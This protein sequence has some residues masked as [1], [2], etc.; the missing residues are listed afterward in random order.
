MDP[1]QEGEEPLALACGVVG[2]VAARLGFTGVGVGVG[3]E[4]LELM[5]HLGLGEGTRIVDLQVCLFLFQPKSFRVVLM[6]SFCFFPWLNKD[7]LPPGIDEP[8]LPALPS[9]T[10]QSHSRPHSHSHSQSHSRSPYT[11]PPPPHPEH[12]HEQNTIPI[13]TSPP[14]PHPEAAHPHPRPHPHPHDQP[15]AH[16][17]PS[18]DASQAASAAGVAATSGP[19]SL[20]PPL[21]LA[22]LAPLAPPPSS[23]SPPPPPPRP[24]HPVRQGGVSGPPPRSVG[25]VEVDE[26]EDA[27]PDYERGGLPPYSRG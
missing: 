26:Q 7:D 11:P 5:E 4:G 8:S 23:S 17:P 21:G 1:P 13:P 24:H 20:P 25:T 16:D 27:P 15:P 19:P 10:N 3:E 14:P 9:F 6:V 18:F 2:E 22:H 12:A